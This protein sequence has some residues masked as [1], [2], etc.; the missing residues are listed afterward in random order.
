MKKINVIKNYRKIIEQL[1]RERA[2]LRAELA[3]EEKQKKRLQ[4]RLKMAGSE[5]K[6]VDGPCGP[7][8]VIEADMEVWG[9]YMELFDDADAAVIANKTLRD[10]VVRNL[11]GKV[12]RDLIKSDIAQVIYKSRESWDEI[13]G[14]RKNATLG[15]KLFV[16]PWEQMRT[17]SRIEIRR[18]IPREEVKRDGRLGEG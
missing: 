14:G 18:Q 7:I 5:I 4:D 15:V 17:G 13:P 11:A 16:V 10:D 9:T 2:L 1:R 3:D 12:A 8:Q 6:T